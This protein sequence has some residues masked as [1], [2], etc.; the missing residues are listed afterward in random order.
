MKLIHILSAAAALAL[1]SSTAFAAGDA[2]A[3]A[4]TFNKC[5]ACHKIGP[6]AKNAVG[7]QLN[8]LSGRKAGSTEYAYSDAM[9]ASGKTWDEATFKEFIAGPQKL[10]PG[11]KMTFPGLSAEA[12]RDNVWAYISQF[13][14]DGSK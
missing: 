7:P 1:M 13:K 6:D 12:D 8:G 3:G 14:A 2:E 10:I 5:G 11:I 9:K 4:K